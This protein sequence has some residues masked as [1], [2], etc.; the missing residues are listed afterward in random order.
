MANEIR[1]FVPSFCV[2]CLCVCVACKKWMRAAAAFGALGAN[3]AHHS[4][5]RLLACPALPVQKVEL[6]RDAHSLL[7]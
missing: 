4:F 1:Q 2:C 3:R 6:L 7:A 5:A